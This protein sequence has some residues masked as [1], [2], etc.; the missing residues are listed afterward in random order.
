MILTG[1]G[2]R[3]IGSSETTSSAELRGEAR[4]NGADVARA[5]A[6]ACAAPRRGGARRAPRARALTRRPAAAAC[7]RRASARRAA[8]SRSTSAPVGA[9]AARHQLGVAPGLD[10]AALVQHEDPVGAAD[11]REAVRD[12]EDERG[13]VPHAARFSSTRSSVSAS[14]DGGRLV[15]DQDR[16]VLE[17]RARD[18]EPLA[19]ARRELRAALA[20]R[21][22]VALRL[23]LDELVGAGDAR[24]L[25]HRG[26]VASGHRVADVLAD[27]RAEEQVLLQRDARRARR[28]LASSK[29]ADVD[30]VD[31]DR[32]ARRARRGAA[33]ATS[34]C[35]LPEPVGPTIAVTVP[36]V[37]SKSTPSSAG[38]SGVVAEA[39]VAEAHAVAE[40]RQR[41]SRPPRPRTSGSRSSSSNTRS[42]P[43]AMS[44]VRPQVRKSARSSPAPSPKRAFDV[45]EEAEVPDREAE[46]RR[47]AIA[48]PR[49][50]AD[51]AERAGRAPSPVA[52]IQNRQTRKLAKRLRALEGGREGAAARAPRS[53]AARRPRRRTP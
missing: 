25:A 12:Q 3:R 41:A 35:V 44:C 9:A 29:P 43:I 13:R 34:A 38:R 20:E 52:A 7:L 5:R 8:L 14:S 26:V 11:R 4:L 17:H 46:R 53:A 33:A 27:R 37:A 39:H 19:L 45:V 49:Q 6:R 42:R 10:D 1:H 51:R 47:R 28:R 30:A 40:R 16:R 50:R 22:V 36:T 21:R 32:A 31:L 48:S 24:G 2:R 23:A 15:E 18:R